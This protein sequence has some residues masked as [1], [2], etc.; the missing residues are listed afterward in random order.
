MS[1][2]I[3]GYSGASVGGFDL[4]SALKKY[5]T[6]ATG[7]TITGQ[8]TFTAPIFAEDEDAA[9]Q[10]ILTASAPAGFENPMVA[11]RDA[12]IAGHTL[13]PDDSAAL[14]LTVNSQTN[15]GIKINPNSII[16]GAGGTS[17][18]P[19]SYLE[20]ATT[21]SIRCVGP[22]PAYTDE[23]VRIAT[24]QWVQNVMRLSVPTGTVSIYGGSTAPSGYVLCNGALYS[25][26]NVLY[27][28][29][30]AVI[31]YTYTF[32]PIFPN[33]AV[34]DLRGIFPNMPG[35]NSQNPYPG[36]VIVGPTA[37]GQHQIQSTVFVDHKHTTNYPSGTNGAAGPSNYDSF[38]TSGSSAQTA[39]SSFANNITTPAY[40][41]L[42]DQVRP[43][44]LGVNYIIKL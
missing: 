5:V 12:V 42:N 33:F 41:T 24:T 35:T 43:Y 1:S 21:G 20:V 31:G 26:S 38:Y 22:E 44:T 25:Q 34:P 36:V 8:K 2:N 15:S 17:V 3:F 27:S 39:S 28:P 29:L 11:D 19:T 37:L 16:M 4:N 10:M 13:D 32:N 23:S 6:L 40:T 18:T 7:Q 9:M 30:Y 14:V